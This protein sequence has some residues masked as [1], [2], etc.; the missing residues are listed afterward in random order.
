MNPRVAERKAWDKFGQEKG[1]AAGPQ[2]DTVS[3]AE[4]IVFRLTER[5]AELKGFATISETLAAVFPAAKPLDLIF[6]KPF[7][8]LLKRESSPRPYFAMWVG[9]PTLLV[10]P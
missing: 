10:S 6:N 8:V 4:N 9:N 5:G 2:T 7:L 3:V 1:K